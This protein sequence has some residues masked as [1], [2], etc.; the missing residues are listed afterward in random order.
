[1]S[2]MNTVNKGTESI[3]QLSFTQQEYRRRLRGIQALM[4]TEDLTAIVVS[5]LSNICY[6]CGFQTIGS[7]GYGLYALIVP[8]QG[9]PTLFTS[10]F[11]SHNAKIV[12]AIED[13]VIYT[14]QEQLDGS[15]IE[16]LADLIHE[17]GFN[18][19][20]VGWECKHYGL[21]AN[22]SNALSSRLR[23]VKWVE[24]SQ[25]IQ[26][27]KL[28]KSPEEIKVLRCAADLTT[29]GTLAG[30]E[31]ATVGRRDNDIAAAIYEKIVTD[32]GEYFSLQPIVTTGRRSGVPHSTFRRV[33]L[34]KGDT[35]FIEVSAAY[36]RYSAPNLRTV[37]V[38]NPSDDA[39]RAWEACR[40]SVAT[41]VENLR[42]GASSQDAA[43]RA[44]KALRSIEDRLVWHG[45]YGYSAGLA[46]PPNCTDCNE[47]GIITETVDF[48][49]KV[50]MVFHINTSLRKIGEFG[51]TMGDTVLVTKTGSQML[52]EVP[53]EMNMLSQ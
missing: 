43:R 38:G 52:T 44:G 10:D 30:I 27:M 36:E 45:Y 32:G 14:V 37:C 40:M 21:T 6:L 4:S 11:E 12:G 35:V 1:M 50:G 19:G 20:L 53:A 9:N 34:K 13:I 16:Q 31:A 18:S 17:R 48:E 7:Y 39:R 3:K 24:C 23:G 29:A 25:I 8:Q 51:V 49:V 5:D 2:K 28:I 22:Q 15:P 47:I 46:F 26:R 41:V 42:D 33:R